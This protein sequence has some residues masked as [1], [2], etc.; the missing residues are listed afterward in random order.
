MA[1]KKIKYYVVWRGK[2]TGVFDTWSECQSQIQGFPGAQYKAFE[3]RKLAE[4]AYAGRYEDYIV[5]GPPITKSS[6][7]GK[8]E[9]GTGPIVPSISVDAACSGN[10]GIVEYRG[11]DT[12][13][14]EELFHIGPLPDGTNNVG[15]F[16]ALVHALAM[17]KQINGT[18]PIYSD[19]RIAM[20]W[21]RQK[22]LG[23]RLE[24]TSKN[25]RIFQLLERALSWLQQNTYP[26][27]VLKWD[28]KNW[29]EIPA[30]FGRK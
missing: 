27:R 13:T 30:D 14:S 26:N 3:S 12:A 4:S 8:L 22:R 21:V 20:L 15:E 18:L 23:T 6:A 24:H 19:S 7:S 1:A 17:Q 16:L 11:V 28:T 10:P 2:N 29:G 9:F 25:V 5:S